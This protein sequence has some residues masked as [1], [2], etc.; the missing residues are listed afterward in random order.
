MCPLT[1]TLALSLSLSLA[2]SLSR[3][4]SLSLFLSLALSLSRS[5]AL[6]ANEPE[7]WQ[8]ILCHICVVFLLPLY[9]AEFLLNPKP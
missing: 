1:T 9:Q 6:D 3:S 5:L 2:L 8:E 7:Y 4:F